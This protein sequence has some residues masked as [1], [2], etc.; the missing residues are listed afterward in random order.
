MNDFSRMAVLAGIDID[1]P[2]LRE[3]L[4]ALAA[5]AAAR[6]GREVGL[7][8][9]VL[10]S[11]Q[12]FAGSYGLHGWLAELGG[13]PIEWSFCVNAVRSGRP[14]VVPD[15]RID[16]LQSTNPL[17]CVDGVR[18]YAGVPIVVD[19]EVLGAHCVLGYAPAEFT[20]ADLEELHRGASEI[21][22]L[23]ISYRRPVTA[24]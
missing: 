18:S 14:Y 21:V 12:F 4:D 10:D 19:G 15:A 11:A 22:E 20:P 6:L 7:I 23:L 24:P 2:S 9:M 17:V 3:K 1:N 13:T 5:R 8:S 16:A